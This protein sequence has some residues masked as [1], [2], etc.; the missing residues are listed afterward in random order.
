VGSRWLKTLGLVIVFGIIALIASVIVGIISAPFGSGSGVVSSILSG[1]YLPIFPIGLTVYYYSNVARIT[2]PTVS[3][4]P[5]APA[6]GVQTGMKFCPYCGTQ[7]V[8]SAM[9]CSKCGAKQT[10]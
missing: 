1:F 9:F 3:T 5:M 10:A 2:P 7:L 8:S 6:P 4:A